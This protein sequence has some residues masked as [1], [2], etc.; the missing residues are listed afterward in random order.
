MN[1]LR[2]KYFKTVLWLILTWQFASVTSSA[3]RFFEQGSVETYLRCAGIFKY[4]F[5]ANFP[6]SVSVKEF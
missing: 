6:L 4:I 2:V 5:I 3:M 1:I